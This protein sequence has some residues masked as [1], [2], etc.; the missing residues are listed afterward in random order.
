MENLSMLNNE[1]S[2][3]DFIK[4]II[5]LPPTI[6]SL[7]SIANSQEF[8]KYK[9]KNNPLDYCSVHFKQPPNE[10]TNEDGITLYKINKDTYRNRN[11]KIHKLDFARPLRIAIETEENHWIDF[12]NGNPWNTDPGFGND[13]EYDMNALHI[14]MSYAH[15]DSLNNDIQD[16]TKKVFTNH[17][18]DIRKWICDCYNWTDDIFYKEL[19][20]K[21]KQRFKDFVTAYRHAIDNSSER[22]NF[23]PQLKIFREYNNQVSSCYDGNF[24]WICLSLPSVGERAIIFTHEINRHNNGERIDWNYINKF[25]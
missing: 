8:S 18:K 9:L 24:P 23:S 20:D 19:N 14:S 5:T 7:E 3:R 2:R 16:K 10:F 22:D 17:P 25:S 12:L 21:N 15:W 11:G 13:P 4:S 1:H 6:L